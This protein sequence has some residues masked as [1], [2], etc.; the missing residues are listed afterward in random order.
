MVQR[1]VVQDVAIGNDQVEV[2]VRVWIHKHTSKAHRQARG[3]FEPREMRAVFKQLCAQVL[4]QRVR[5]VIKARHEQVHVAV[6]IDIS[7]RHAHRGFGAAVTVHSGAGEQGR[8]L[9]GAATSV[10]PQAVLCGVV[11]YIQVQVRIVV[12]VCDRHAQ[13][14][15][16][17]IHDA[18]SLCALAEH[19]L[20]VVLVV[21]I[22][23]SRVAIWMT[24]RTPTFFALA[25]IL[26]IREVNGEVGHQVQVQVTIRIGVEESCAGAPLIDVHAAGF[27]AVDPVGGAIPV[28]DFGL[29]Q[30]RQHKIRPPVGI[31]ITHGDAHA[32]R[33]VGCRA[34]GGGGVCKV[35]LTVIQP[36]LVRRSVGSRRCVAGG[37]WALRGHGAALHQIQVQVAVQ[38]GV[39]E[40]GTCSHGFGQMAL[41]AAAG[42]MCK[43]YL[44]GLGRRGVPRASGIRVLRGLAGHEPAEART[45]PGNSVETLH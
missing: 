34:A 24:V 3:L 28:Q 4:V 36:Q 35:C 33:A 44:T 26:G 42:H 19:T 25:A 45:D 23:E 8:V 40:R 38:I 6:V 9:E 20:A 27:C 11:R 1:D 14:F 5:L 21:A 37:R 31:H 16:I 2:A 29:A 17:G 30:I 12:D 39:E 13:A 7:E 41:G 32:V 43:A 22:V 18:R 10:G 15:A